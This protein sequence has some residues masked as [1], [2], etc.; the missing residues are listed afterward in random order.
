MHS[1]GAGV[2]WGQY[3]GRGDKMFRLQVQSIMAYLRNR[4]GQYDWNKK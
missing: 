3:L 4:M 1:D 2:I